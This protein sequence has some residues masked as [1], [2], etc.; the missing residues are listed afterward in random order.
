MNLELHYKK[1]KP[2]RPAVERVTLEMTYDEAKELRVILG[3]SH[4]SGSYA[5]WKVIS[6]T[7]DAYDEDVV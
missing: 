7:M 6:D 4:S 1:V 5:F 3:A 2:V